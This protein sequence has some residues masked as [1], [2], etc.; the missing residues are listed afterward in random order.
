MSSPTRAARGA[1][2]ATASF[3]F[4][5]LVPLYW[6]QMSSIASLELIMHR[7]VWSLLF[8]I[9]I[10][11]WQN[12]LQTLRAAFAYPRLIGLNLLS[13][14]LLAA[15]WTVYIWAGNHGQVI[16]SSLGYFL[17]PL[18]NVALGSLLLHERL[19]ALQ[20]LAISL[21][22]A[23]VIILLAR[24]GHVPWIALA[25][26]ATWSGYG[27]LKKKSALGA[28]PGLTAETLI[29]L[30]LALGLLGWWH[31]TGT[32]A[33]GRVDWWQHSL[34]LSVGVVTAIPLLLFA[35]GA[36]RIPLTTLGLLQYLAP[37]VQFL[38]GYFLYHEPFD[39]VHLQ[40][41]ACIWTGLLLYIGDGF[42]AQRHHLRA[43][44]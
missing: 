24:L 33:L 36:Q 44:T 40:A 4:W 28:I 9:G 13:S 16:E 25:I 15:N 39:L 42:W 23:G 6:K 43:S 5:G 20:W 12:N 19:R 41:Y 38:L 14:L 17:V 29:L 35:Y 26:A 32:G 8:L 31:H 11:A 30:P 22:A 3:L 10:L 27:L 2:A 7:I 34:I 21:A 1:L 18:V 37:S